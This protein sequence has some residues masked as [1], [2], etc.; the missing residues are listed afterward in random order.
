MA[1]TNANQ[2]PTR[3]PP[4]CHTYPA[5]RLGGPAASPSCRLPAPAPTTDH[6]IAALAMSSPTPRPLRDPIPRH[7]SCGATGPA[8]TRRLRQTTAFVAHKQRPT[9]ASSGV[10]Q[11]TTDTE[12]TATIPLVRARAQCTIGKPTGPGL[13]TTRG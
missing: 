11:P 1:F 10:A 4:D 12:A 8:R 7:P 13:W 2:R 9:A 6:A 5:Q 3:L